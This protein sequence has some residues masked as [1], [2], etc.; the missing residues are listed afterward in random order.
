[1]P[2]PPQAERNASLAV[3]L[4][5]QLSQRQIGLRYHPIHYLTLRLGTGPPLTPRLMRYPLGLPITVP[6][7]GNL[8]RPANA[9]QKA[10]R[11]FFQRLLAL[12]VSQQKF[13]AQ[14]IPIWLRHRFTCRRVSPILSLHYYRNCS[15][16]ADCMYGLKPVP[17]TH[18]RPYRRQE[19]CP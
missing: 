13:T 17:S 14:V 19:F 3:Q 9:H 11:K 16:I 15:N 18:S 7:R 8:L 1:M 4:G 2:D 12:I 6:L 10:I 5:L